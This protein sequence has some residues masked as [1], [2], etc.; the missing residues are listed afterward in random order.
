[1]IIALH[2]QARTTPMVVLARRHN[3]AEMTVRK[4]KGRTECRGRPHVSVFCRR[5]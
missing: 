3:V 4:W 2:Q 1:M 5:R